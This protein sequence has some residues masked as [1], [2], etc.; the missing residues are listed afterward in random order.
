[1]A[2]PGARRIDATFSGRAVLRRRPDLRTGEDRDSAW[3]R[4]G[5]G[6]YVRENIWAASQHRPTLVSFCAALGLLA[7]VAVAH[8]Q[9][10]PPP[11]VPAVPQSA[12]PIS[13]IIATA[14]P[15]ANFVAAA[16]RMATVHAQNGRLRELAR[17]LAKN[18][19]SVANSLTARVNVIGP[20]IAR[21]APSA[22]GAG[23]GPNLSAPQLL[24][25]QASTLRQ[26]S[27]L[28]GPS[29][30]AF[31]VSSVKES[32]AQLQTLYRDVAKADGD[33]ELRSLAQRELPKLEETISALNAI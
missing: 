4:R 16:S 27:R 29:F 7:L 23:G 13:R 32:L 28:R 33:A 10:E 26:L 15:S 6:A 20:V 25:D 3:R 17:D 18:Q 11:E 2:T 9:P 8:A 24:P 22:G 5:I 19:T 14:I 12:E 30:D 31:Y 21:R 1:M